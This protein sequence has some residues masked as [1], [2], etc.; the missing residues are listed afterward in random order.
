[1]NL[2]PRFGQ[3][4]KIALERILP[5]SMEA[6]M[7]VLGAMLVNPAEATPQVRERLDSSHFYSASHQAIFSEIASLQDSLK[8]IDVVTLVQRFDD[9]GVLKDIGGESYLSELVKQ[10][11]PTA[12]IAHHVNI[13][14]ERHQLRDLI[15]VTHD[16]LNHAFDRHSDV[17]AWMDEVEQRIFNIN[18]DPVGT[19]VESAKDIVRQ[20]MGEI[21]R[22][23]ENPR[24]LIGLST[25]FRD[26]DRL[27]LGLRS[28]YVYVIAARPSMGKTALA[29][30]IVEN[31]AIDQNVPV[32][33]FSLDLSSEELVN[34][35]LCSRASVNLRAVY[36][37]LLK[38][39]DCTELTT[40]ASKLIKAPFYIDDT[41]GL[42][43]NQVR[44]RARRMFMKHRIRLL[45]IDYIQVMSR[46]D[47]A[48]DITSGIKTLA[49]ELEIPV[50]VLSQLNRQ[51]ESRAGG[52]PRLGDLRRFDSLTQEAAVVGLLIRPE[53]YEDDAVS[54][55]KLRGLAQL[56]IAKQRNGPTG[57]VNLNFRSEYARFDDAAPV[58][59]N[60]SPLGGPRPVN[61]VSTN[62]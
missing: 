17:P 35:M 26:L 20:V 28:G 60:N 8:P 22:R 18:A 46:R 57:T 16:I 54:R 62:D 25:G 59:P 42:T 29:M 3:K 50:I 58:I 31:I 24:S 12:N 49:K 61:P 40:A 10:A 55:E 2:E 11:P 53:V 56:F 21:E 27:T 45:V 23:L 36:D 47:K 9:Q 32:G 34:R 15:N 43:I 14:W 38:E 30:N 44:A 1:M 51:P 41:V 19:G 5:N 48:A 6:E 39:T 13:V 7:A 52:V 37:G 4:F 33:V